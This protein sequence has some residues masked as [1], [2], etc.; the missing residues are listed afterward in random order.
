MSFVG[1]HEPFDTPA[2]WA[3]RHR[4]EALPP[5]EPAP[6]WADQLPEDSDLARLRRRW[7]GRLSPAAI[8]ACRADYAD[9]LRLLDD[10]LGRLLEALANRG[11][12][13]RTAVLATADHG[14]LLG[15]WDALYKGALLESA[16]RVPW[17]YRPP[18]GCRP[19][20]WRRPLPLTELLAQ[21]WA[22]LPQGGGVDRL[23]RWVRGCSAA[24]VEFGEELLVLQGQ[25]K[26]VLDG[27]GQP[28][29]AS[30]VRSNGA[31][32]TEVIRQQPW[33][34]RLSPGWRRLRRRGGQEWQRRR[35]AGW[36]WRDLRP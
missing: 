26:L 5:A 19:Q 32:R 23:R 2:P 28:L 30:R 25:R 10:Q 15:D 33:R 35:S 13:D 18:G 31:D 27:Q 21:C 36:L 1:P 8:Q 9:H 3:G 34:W 24:V 6:A 7:Q 11:D 17:V 29:W 12:A 4:A 22:G 20:R 16:V 14:E